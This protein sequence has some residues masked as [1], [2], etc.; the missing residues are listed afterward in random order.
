VFL[1]CMVKTAVNRGLLRPIVCWHVSFQSLACDLYSFWVDV[2][3]NCTI[4]MSASSYLAKNQITE[5]SSSANLA[6]DY[7]IPITI[8]DSNNII[9]TVEIGSDSTASDLVDHNLLEYNLPPKPPKSIAEVRLIGNDVNLSRDI[10][11]FDKTLKEFI[12]NIQPGDFTY[13]ISINWNI[14]DIPNMSFSIA[15]NFEQ[16]FISDI[17]MNEVSNIVIPDSLN[18]LTQ[19]K[20][21]GYFK[22]SDI[23]IIPESFALHPNYPNPFNPITRIRYDLPEPVDVYLDVYNILGRHVITLFNDYQEAGQ[24][25]VVWNSRDKLGISVSSGVYFV[26]ISAGIH[27]R[28]HKI[29]LLK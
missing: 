13:P 12:I 15:D 7:L 21:T 20:I 9:R 22:E 25:S 1:K 24:Y 26:R 27:I 29:L 3:Q 4:T 6:I 17:V 14:Q 10:R 18:F 19:F 28:S 2:N 23:N 8:S 11:K 16:K 5:V